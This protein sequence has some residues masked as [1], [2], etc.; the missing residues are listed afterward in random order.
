MAAGKKYVSKLLKNKTQKKLMELTKEIIRLLDEK[1]EPDRTP[2]TT[3]LGGNTLLNPR[4][5]D[6]CMSSPQG[7]GL[8]RH[9]TSN[10]IGPSLSLGPFF[11][12]PP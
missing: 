4:F 11:I 1:P 2:E 6:S 7:L 8:W 12:P 3:A 5:S 9:E 10:L